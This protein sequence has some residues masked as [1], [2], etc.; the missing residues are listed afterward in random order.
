MKRLGCQHL[1]RVVDVK[2]GPTVPGSRSTGNLSVAVEKNFTP[3][4]SICKSSNR[5]RVVI[6]NIGGLFDFC[7]GD[8]RIHAVACRMRRK[9]LTVAILYSCAMFSI[10]QMHLL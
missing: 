10:S 7:S 5:G 3:R 4:V 6:T 2:S 1:K 8:K 9:F